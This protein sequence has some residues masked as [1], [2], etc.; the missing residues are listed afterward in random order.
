MLFVNDSKL[1]S[2]IFI[3]HHNDHLANKTT[4]DFF[5]AKSCYAR[6]VEKSKLVVCVI[7]THFTNWVMNRHFPHP[8]IG[9]HIYYFSSQ[10]R[11]LSQRHNSSTDQYLYSSNTLLRHFDNNLTKHTLIR[12]L[13]IDTRDQ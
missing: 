6:R 9:W 7:C 5:R 3:I 12:S 1:Q 4:M 13:Y 11:S 10:N 8:P 2:R